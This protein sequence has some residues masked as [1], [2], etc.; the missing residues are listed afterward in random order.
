VRIVEVGSSNFGILRRKPGTLSQFSSDISFRVDDTKEFME[1]YPIAR[2]QTQ[3]LYIVISMLRTLC[4]LV[5]VVGSLSLQKDHFGAE[6][7]KVELQEMVG[8]VN[9]EARTTTTY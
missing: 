6:W 7:W 8:F 4:Q 5:A 3:T 9:C 1:T 2:L